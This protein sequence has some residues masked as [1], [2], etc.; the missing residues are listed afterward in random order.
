MMLSYVALAALFS[1]AHS[2]C[3]S[4]SECSL[5]GFK[6]DVD[7]AVCYPACS[8]DDDCNANMDQPDAGHQTATTL[9]Q[10]VDH[11]LEMELHGTRAPLLS[12]L[13]PSMWVLLVAKFTQST[14]TQM[15]G[16][17]YPVVFAQE[18]NISAR[19]AG[20]LYGGGTVLACLVLW[21]GPKMC[22]H[23]DKLNC[24]KS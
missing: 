11:S 15:Y 4:D 6:C 1:C 17:A 19:I 18:F 16:I 14:C 10:S 5:Y 7:N 8:V 21:F 13:S 24:V 9:T 22:A 23:G 12:T 2:Q 20:F 3:S